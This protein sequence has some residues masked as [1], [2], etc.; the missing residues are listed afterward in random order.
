MPSRRLGGA[1]AALL[2]ASSWL[3]CE[4][5]PELTFVSEEG[6]TDGGGRDGST[7]GDAARDAPDGGDASSACTTPSPGAGALC[8]GAVWCQD[9]TQAN[10]EECA[11][12]GCSGSDLC[13]PTGGTVTC[14]ARCR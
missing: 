4:P 13:C 12:R 11:R 2:L 6:G 14:K 9:C 7:P 8:C 1:A 10:C 5:V 3:G